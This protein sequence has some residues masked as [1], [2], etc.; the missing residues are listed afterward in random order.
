MRTHRFSFEKYY[1]DKVFMGIIRIIRFIFTFFGLVLGLGGAFFIIANENSN[2]KFFHDI[3][4][5]NPGLNLSTSI[6][7]TVV[8]SI[9]LI[10]GVIFF[11]IYYQ[12]KDMY[13]LRKYCMDAGDYASLSFLS[14]L[15]RKA[16]NPNGFIDSVSKA[17]VQ[18]YNH[19]QFIH[20]PMCVYNPK[21]KNIK[22]FSKLYNDN[23]QVV[24]EISSS[25]LL[26]NI[27]YL[28]RDGSSRKYGVGIMISLSYIAIL[29]HEGMFNTDELTNAAKYSR[30]AIKACKKD[31]SVEF[32]PHEGVVK[33]VIDNNGALSVESNYSYA[34]NL[35]NE[36]ESN[37][38][39]K[40]IFDK[41]D[42]IFNK[43]PS[44][45]KAYYQKIADMLKI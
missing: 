41:L 37:G 43:Q 6:L 39:C 1:N 13:W 28:N 40:P 22:I 44:Q 9:F 17:G 33:L 12:N 26:V 3:L 10:M 23:R 32:I 2:T 36:M 27:G 45:I 31:A 15:S 5:S 7:L 30:E 25:P 24:I 11:I 34:K 42:N 19:R 35:V 21:V 16:I 8:G 14:S 38:Y 20:H 29:D 18:L 4:L